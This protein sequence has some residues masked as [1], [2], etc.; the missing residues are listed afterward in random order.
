MSSARHLHYHPQL[1]TDLQP[2]HFA[3]QSTTM[4]SDEKRSKVTMKPIDPRAAGSNKDT[5]ELI[6]LCH[7]TVATA[8][9]AQ[10]LASLIPSEPSLFNLGPVRLG[11][12]ARDRALDLWTRQ[13][14]GKLVNPPW[15]EEEEARHE[16]DGSEGGT[17]RYL[18]S[19]N[20]ANLHEASRGENAPTS[21][22]A[23]GVKHPKFPNFDIKNWE[24]MLALESKVIP[25]SVDGDR[26][27][28]SSGNDQGIGLRSQQDESEWDAVTAATQKVPKNERNKVTGGK[29]LKSSL[30]S[31]E[32]KLKERKT[33]VQFE[34]E[35]NSNNAGEG[36]PALAEMVFESAMAA[37]NPSEVSLTAREDNEPLE[38]RGDS[39]SQSRPVVSPSKDGQCDRTHHEDGGGDDVENAA[40]NYPD[41]EVKQAGIHSRGVIE[42]EAL[43]DTEENSE[44]AESGSMSPRLKTSVVAKTN[45]RMLKRLGSLAKKPSL[46]SGWGFKVPPNIQTQSISGKSIMHKAGSDITPRE[47][48]RPA[49]PLGD[50]VASEPVI[51]KNVSSTSEIKVLNNVMRMKKKSRL[52]FGKVSPQRRASLIK[53]NKIIRKPSDEAGRG[54][55][56]DEQAGRLEK[57][58][59]TGSKVLVVDYREHADSSQDL[60]EEDLGGE[61]QKV[62]KRSS[63][64]LNMY[65][66]DLNG[67]RQSKIVVTP[68]RS[69]K[70]LSRDKGR[71]RPQVRRRGRIM[72]R[73]VAASPSTIAKLWRQVDKSRLHRRQELPDKRSSLGSTRGRKAVR[74]VKTQVK[75]ETEGKVPGES[76]TSQSPSLMTHPWSPEPVLQ[77]DDEEE[78]DKSMSRSTPT[79][80]QSRCALSPDTCGRNGLAGKAARRLRKDYFGESQLARDQQRM[81]DLRGSTIYLSVRPRERMLH[82]SPPRVV[83]RPK[84]K[85]VKPKV[86]D[87]VKK[88]PVIPANSIWSLDTASRKRTGSWKAIKVMAGKRHKADKSSNANTAVN[89]PLNR[90]TLRRESSTKAPVVKTKP[91]RTAP[92]SGSTMSW[93]RPPTG[94]FAKA[95][96]ECQIAAQRC[97]ELKN[98]MSAP[99]T[100]FGHSPISRDRDMPKSVSKPLAKP[101][102]PTREVRKAGKITVANRK[103]EQTKPPAPLETAP[104]QRLV[105]N[106]P[107]GR[108]VTTETVKE[109]SVLKSPR[110][111]PHQGDG[112]IHKS[113]ELT[114]REDDSHGRLALRS[115]PRI[116]PKG[117]ASASEFN[118]KKAVPVT[119]LSPEI[120]MWRLAPIPSEIGDNTLSSLSLPTDTGASTTQGT[121]VFP[122]ALLEEEEKHRRLPLKRFG[123]SWAKQVQ[124]RQRFNVPRVGVL[125]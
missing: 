111:R 48:P 12:E 101:R 6:K 49:S 45:E 100:Q 72:R 50:K 71:D 114:L 44:Q 4:K 20:T 28:K 105:K 103:D 87:G 2:P 81:D 11:T 99:A 74:S 88:L 29:T 89:F 76:Q 69:T 53:E 3:C 33:R 67:H 32:S 92:S 109:S 82:L 112:D 75:L 13:E 1:R 120:P 30:C 18:A 84:F 35:C 37:S 80:S 22:S 40:E 7:R 78:A 116:P 64:L 77:A 68:R 125:G 17:P 94:V 107:R 86:T 90:A 59:S 21:A 95:V 106:K 46:S 91:R 19:C 60:D 117:F 110:Y 123:P 26:G 57:T 14:L 58:G 70:D 73:A 124:F 121:D 97:Q 43:T 8:P 85:A 118:L 42:M 56:R 54:R 38:A 119:R 66:Y 16:D 79:D 96:A 63:T 39:E 27:C 108:Q 25:F 52:D 9:S 10:A 15:E 23:I 122:A 36:K 55:G 41:G 34:I 31:V 62:R 65:E 113:P 98:R 102:P 104:N 47:K 5:E 83:D 51:N 61:V 93:R 24:D 115:P